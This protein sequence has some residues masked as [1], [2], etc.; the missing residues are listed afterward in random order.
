MAIASAAGASWRRSGYLNESGYLHN[1]IYG[2]SASI[3]QLA[4]LK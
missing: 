2:L 3:S 4:C 1:I